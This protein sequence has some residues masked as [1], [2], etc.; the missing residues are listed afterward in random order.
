MKRLGA[1][2]RRGWT[3]FTAAIFA[4]GGM[5]AG[6]ALITS[7]NLSTFLIFDAGPKH[8]ENLIVIASVGIATFVS[9]ACVWWLVVES[10]RTA[11]NFRGALVGV[12]TVIAAHLLTILPIGMSVYLPMFSRSSDVESV[13]A[14]YVHSVIG[15]TLI[16]TF[17]SL[18]FLESFSSRLE[19][20]PE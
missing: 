12:I 20:S 7:L 8:L 5:M 15:Y 6:G 4:L 19:S 1:L 18:L 2:S 13:V 10:P 9:S 14:V 11:T 16:L 3:L 17:Y